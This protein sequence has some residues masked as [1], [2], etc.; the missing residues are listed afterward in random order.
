M[1]RKEFL[2]LLGISAATLF[3]AGCLGSCSSSKSED[4][5]PGGG[6]TVPGTG[7][8]GK[9]DFTLNLSNASNAILKTPGSA[10][11]SN[12]VIVAFTNN[13]TY[14]AVSSVC[15]HQGATLGYDANGKRFNCPLHG[16]N[17]NENGS[18]INGPATT[19]LKQYKTTLTGDNLRVFED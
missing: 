17:F 11:I 19:A 18:V 16:S 5:K 15:T 12:G 2:S 3:S 13:S 10:L 9:K 8:S 6:N 14:V 7:T 1:E 4:P